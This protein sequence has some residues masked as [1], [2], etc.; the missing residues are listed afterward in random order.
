M[1][2]LFDVLRRQ[3]YDPDCPEKLHLKVPTTVDEV[4]RFV[5][6][7]REV[8]YDEESDVRILLAT[9]IC[10]FGPPQWKIVG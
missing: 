9:L 4:V 8:P 5:G 6:S 1:T 2:L 3:G 10:E 7:L